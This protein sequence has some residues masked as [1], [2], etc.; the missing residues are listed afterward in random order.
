MLRT[1]NNMIGGFKTSGDA[2][3]SSK[4]I[5]ALGLIVF[6]EENPRCGLPPS[7]EEQY[8]YEWT[9]ANLDIDGNQV[10]D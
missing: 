10:L 9:F 4:R 7:Q 5:M 3:A 1:A 2:A 8:L 6:D